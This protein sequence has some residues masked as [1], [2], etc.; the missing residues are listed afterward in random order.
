[1]PD[2]D[3]QTGGRGSPEWRLT[4]AAVCVVLVFGLAYFRLRQEPEEPWPDVSIYAGTAQSLLAGGTYRF[5]GAPEVEYPPG[6]P[7]AYY[8]IGRAVGLTYETRAMFNA[9]S[10]ALGLL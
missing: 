9:L 2:W 5:N 7:L 6:V 8:L 3:P 10:A 4:A 1:M